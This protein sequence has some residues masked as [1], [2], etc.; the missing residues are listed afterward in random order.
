MHGLGNDYVFIDAFPAETNAQLAQTDL[1]ALACAIS[2]RHRGV[3]SDGLVLILPDKKADARMRMFN[4]DGSEAQMCGN[5]IRCVGKYLYESGACP[6]TNLRIATQAGLRELELHVQGDRVMSV[7]V[8]MGKPVVTAHR[9]TTEG[10]ERPFFFVNMG[11]PHAV[12]FH[13]TMP[14]TKTI[15]S[16][17]ARIEEHPSFPNRTN[18]EFVVRGA[19]N[20]LHMRV[21]ERG[22][23][24]TMAC[25]TGACAAAVAS[26]QKWDM[27][28]EITVHLLGGDLSIRQDSKGVVYMTGAAEESFRGEF[29]WN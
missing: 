22:T 21:W 18:V 29:Q 16:R 14:D 8:N 1:S 7:T 4:A 26:M 12:F 17:G 10:K 20:D 3:G 5:A 19:N 13:E 24:E 6:R 15:R 9:L 27:P 2:D 28:N 11:N 23:G 25:G